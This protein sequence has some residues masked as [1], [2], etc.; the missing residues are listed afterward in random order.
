VSAAA[1]DVRVREARRRLAGL[2]SDDELAH[3]TPVQL[4]VELARAHGAPQMLDAWI[5]EQPTEAAA[6]STAQLGCVLGALAYRRRR[7]EAWC[8]DC[9]ASAAG[10]CSDHLDD[11]DAADTYRD[12]AGL[13]RRKAEGKP[14]GRRAGSKDRRPRKRSGYVARRERERARRKAS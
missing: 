4:L 5:R 2:P 14:V 12:L 11:L 10:A 7:A 6:L 1:D 9:E 3:L 13:A 8:G